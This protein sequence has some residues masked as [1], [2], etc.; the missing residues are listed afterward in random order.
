MRHCPGLRAPLTRGKGVCRDGGPGAEDPASTA[1]GAWARGVGFGAAA[2]PGWR[3]GRPRCWLHWQ[4]HWVSRPLAFCRFQK[5]ERPQ[6]N[7]SVCSE[8]GV[9]RSR[10]EAAPL[11]RAPRGSPSR[12]LRQAPGHLRTPAGHHDTA[13]SR[14]GPS[15]H[16][17]EGIVK[18]GRLWWRC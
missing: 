12:G 11:R 9:V 17:K 3:H 13:K 4:S 8:A 14:A 1:S 18:V 6:L 15:G 7:G 16:L 5:A 10:H 2:A